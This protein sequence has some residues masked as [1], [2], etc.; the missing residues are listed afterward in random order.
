MI[1]CLKPGNRRKHLDKAKWKQKQQY[2]KK[3]RGAKAEVGDRVLVKILAY[4]EG[5]HKSADK[6]EE[7][8]YTVVEQPCQDWYTSL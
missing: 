4:K 3:E 7:D 1:E 6:Y 8:F 5:K 2:D